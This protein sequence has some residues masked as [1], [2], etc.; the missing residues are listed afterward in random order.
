LTAEEAEAGW[1]FKVYDD[2]NVLA[3]EMET[4]LN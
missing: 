2:C 1:K 4:N 3:V